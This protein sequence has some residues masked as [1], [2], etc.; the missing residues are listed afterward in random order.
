MDLRDC[1]LRLSKALGT[2]AQ[3]WLNLQNRYDVEVAERPIGKKLAK[4]SRITG[5]EAASLSG[6]KQTETAG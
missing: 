2:S 6:R 4:I 5:K 3:L 1:G